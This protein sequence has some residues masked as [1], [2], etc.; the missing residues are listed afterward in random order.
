MVSVE[1][2]VEREQ[3]HIGIILRRLAI[4]SSR[5]RLPPIN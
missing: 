1:V 2:I 3:L 4:D 5:D